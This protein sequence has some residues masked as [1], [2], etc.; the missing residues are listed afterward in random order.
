[1]HHGVAR[2]SRD[3]RNDRSKSAFVAYSA[4][5]SSAPSPANPFR[6]IFDGKVL[7]AVVLIAGTTIGGGTLALPTVANPAGFVPAVACLTLCWL[8]LMLEGLLLVEVTDAVSQDVSAKASGAAEG[9]SSGEREIVSFEALADYSLGR[10]GGQF[11]GLVYQLYSYAGMLA[12]V[13][14]LGELLSRILLNLNMAISSEV[15]QVVGVFGLW[16]IIMIGG[17]KGMER[18]NEKLN[19]IF[20]ALMAFILAVGLVKLAPGALVAHADWSKAPAAAGV[21]LFNVVFHDV[22]PLVC[23]YLK[24]DR[25]KIA[26]AIIVGSS[27]PLFVYVMWLAVSLSAAGASTVFVDPVATMM[28]SGGVFGTIVLIWGFLAL[29]TSLIGCGMAQAEYEA[30]LL[31]KWTSPLRTIATKTNTLG[32]FVKMAISKAGIEWFS[33]AAV[34]LPPLAISVAFPGLFVAAA[35][36]SGAYGVAVLFGVLPPLMAW[37]LRSKAGSSQVPLVGGGRWMLALLFLGGLSVALYQTA[38][39]IA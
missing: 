20:F 21:V 22:I 16:A 4:S 31:R 36:F 14:A 5:S 33:Y 23:D 19:Y 34:L 2:H 26:A 8:F 24:F 11:T 35:D 18:V 15:G 7:S 6:A 38:S 27:I 25:V 1:M 12:Y 37:R 13:A 30:E 29:I 28:S 9:S 32:K 10:T 3:T 39:Y 17:S